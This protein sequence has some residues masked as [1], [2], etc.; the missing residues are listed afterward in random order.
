MTSQIKVLLFPNFQRSF[1]PPPRFAR[2]HAYAFLPGLF[3]PLFLTECKGKGRFI[4]TKFSGIYF[5]IK[6][7]YFGVKINLFCEELDVL[8]LNLSTAFFE[9]DG[10]GKT[11]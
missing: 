11:L 4:S 5:S 6:F 3:I 1:A 7:E 8:R 9:A 2:S 10:K